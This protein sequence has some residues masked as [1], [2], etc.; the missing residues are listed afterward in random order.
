LEAEGYRTPIPDKP[1]RTTKNKHSK[2][3]SL[4][5]W[6]AKRPCRN[7]ATYTGEEPCE[8]PLQEMLENAFISDILRLFPSL[9]CI[10]S[11]LQLVRNSS[12]NY[13][14]TGKSNFLEAMKHKT[15][16]LNSNLAMYKPCWCTEWPESED[17][18]EYCWDRLSASILP[19]LK[20]QL[21]TLT[22]LLQEH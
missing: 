20:S 17:R 15:M 2:F 5:L 13:K 16:N 10:V 6:E 12:H 3:F 11:F 21:S 14:P 4:S 18:T 7:P 8:P 1:G 19:N 9:I 22:E